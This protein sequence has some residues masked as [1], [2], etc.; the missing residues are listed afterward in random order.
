MLRL[1]PR[2]TA[3]VLIDVRDGERRRPVAAGLPGASAE[4]A[5]RFRQAG[6]TVVLVRTG[7]PPAPVVANEGAVAGCAA[8]PPDGEGLADILITEQRWDAFHG[9]DL[10]VQLRR[11]GVRTIVLAGDFGIEATAVVAWERGYEV[12][13]AKD[14][15]MDL[16]CELRHFSSPSAALT[17]E[18]DPMRDGTFVVSTAAVRD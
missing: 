14:A 9:T 12:V 4:L 17:F 1:D 13:I 11:R 3:L 8:G 18:E 7:W 16:A 5:G 15:P 10:D 6:A 2:T